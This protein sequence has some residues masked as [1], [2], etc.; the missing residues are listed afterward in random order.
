MY[1]IRSYYVE[2][3]ADKAADIETQGLGIQGDLGARDDPRLLELLH[4]HMDGGRA[5][6][7]EL[8][9]LGIGGTGIVHQGSE[10]L[11]VQIIDP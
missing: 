8:G 1:A 6:T 5:D 7:I 4:P 9:Q 3:D 11:A 10:D 2:V